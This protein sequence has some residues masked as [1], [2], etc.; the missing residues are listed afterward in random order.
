MSDILNID[1]VDHD[2]LAR[3]TAES[4]LIA[5]A[6]IQLVTR[7]AEANQEAEPRLRTLRWLQAMMIFGNAIPGAQA[8]GLM[9]PADR[10]SSRCSGLR[11]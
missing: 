2:Q 8:A 6:T 11:R 7:L 4:Y 5:Q 9:R 3:I 1:E 10:S